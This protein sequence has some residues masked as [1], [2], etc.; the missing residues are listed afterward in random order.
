MAQF[1]S[2]IKTMKSARIG[3]IMPWAGDGNEGFTIANLPKGWIVCDGQLKDATDYPLLASELG[4]TY[5]G[6]MQGV[7]PNYSGQFKLPNIGN[8]VLIDLEN[9]MLNDTKYQNGQSDAFTVV[10]SLVGD[11]SGDDV[12]SDFGPDATP[13]TYNA[14]A[15]I[16]FTF[17]NPNI[18]LSGRFTGQTISDPDFFTSI[19]T[20][21]RKL[22]IN[23][24]PA[25][26][27]IDTFTS[28]I[29]GFGG[30]QIFDTIGVSIGGSTNHPNGTCSS[31]IVSRNNECSITGGESKAPSWREGS[32]FLSYYGNEDYEHTLPVASRFHLFQNDPGVDYW[33]TVPAPSWHDGTPTRVSPQGATQ[34]VNRPATGEATPAFTYEPF[35]NDPTTTT[36]PV[37]YHPSWTGLHPRPQVNSNYRNYF[38]ASTGNTYNGL[39][40]NP[41]DPANHFIVS[42]VDVVAGVDEIVLPTGTDIRTGK[43]EGAGATA[44][45]YYIE[46]KIRP[47]KVVDGEGIQP[48]THITK[49]TR[50]GNDLASYVYTIELSE[51]TLPSAS[52]GTTL[53]FMEGT[54]ASTVN[55]IGSMD[56]NDSTFQSHN[57]G[58]VDVQMSAGSLKPP[59]SFA[60][61]NVGLGNVVPQSEDNALNITVT[62]SQPAMAAVYIIKAY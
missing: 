31:T 41:E 3:T 55:N 8:K 60:L 5:G 46:D 39:D 24:T 28:A 1:Y 35:D 40:D 10:G 22:N 21:N 9:S 6:T 19:S 25:H 17:N 45:T 38:G 32:T 15:D 51:N 12:G 43:V 37:H 4:K 16:D 29:A 33:S 26:Q 42:N 53:T 57:H 34:S 11:G 48:G 56:P 27:H 36:K 7:F 49:V 23:H 14:F 13:I 2:S 62:V 59:P 47:Y 54:F 30:P 58:T 50:T 61:S 18:L 44:Q 52:S 20:I